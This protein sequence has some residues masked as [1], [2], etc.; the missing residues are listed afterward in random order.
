MHMTPIDGRRKPRGVIPFTSILGATVRGG[1]VDGD[2]GGNLNVASRQD[3]DESHA[4]QQSTG[5][6]FSISQCGASASLSVSKGKADGSYAT[7]LSRCAV[8]NGGIKAT[9]K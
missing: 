6:G 7:L 8:P 3:T 4:R 1:K 2:V 5:G 9:G